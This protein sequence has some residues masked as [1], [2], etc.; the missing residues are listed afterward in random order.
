[1]MYQRKIFKKIKGARKIIFS[2][3]DFS[4]SDSA[5][6]DEMIAQL[7]EKFHVTG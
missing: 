2:L 7:K 1:M 5:G 4:D 3:K 6:E